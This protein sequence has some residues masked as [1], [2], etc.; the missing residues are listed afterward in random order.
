MNQHNHFISVV[1]M[2]FP[3]LFS[4]PATVDKLNQKTAKKHVFPPAAY[5]TAFILDFEAMHNHLQ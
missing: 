1:A 5:D 2:L 4:T 3:P